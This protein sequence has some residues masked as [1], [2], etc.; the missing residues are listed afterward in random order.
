MI[1]WSIEDMRDTSAATLRRCS[2]PSAIEVLSNVEGSTQL[3]LLI[4]SLGTSAERSRST[5]S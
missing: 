2:V 3:T 5:R 1:L 4:R